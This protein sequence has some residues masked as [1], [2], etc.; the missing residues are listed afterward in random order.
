MFEDVDAGRFSP[1]D[2]D[3]ASD[4]ELLAAIWTRNEV[5]DLAAATLWGELHRRYPSEPR[6]LLLTLF[7]SLSEPPVPGSSAGQHFVQQAE[8]LADRAPE[9]TA[10]IA[11][12]LTL[13]AP[14]FA[15]ELEPSESRALAVLH[16][17]VVPQGYDESSASSRLRDLEAKVIAEFDD[18]TASG[19]P[20]LPRA[21]D[22][23]ATVVSVS[24]RDYDPNSRFAVGDRIRHA[25]FGQ[26]VVV[27]VLDQKVE[28]RFMSGTKR[29]ACANGNCE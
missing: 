29:L 5:G 26:G 25:K 17:R 20:L 2:F 6:F 28:V 14:L 4:R 21:G 10:F 13:G 18:L 7:E 12:L 16:A 22:A 24:E 27:A 9:L 1:E 15:S 8:R 11:D 23:A 3:S 19:H